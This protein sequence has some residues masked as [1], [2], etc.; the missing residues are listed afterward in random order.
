MLKDALAAAGGVISEAARLLG[1]SRAHAY[2]LY[3]RLKEEERNAAETQFSASLHGDASS[4]HGRPNPLGEE[5]PGVD[6]QP[7]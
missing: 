7:R 3:K 2:R 5:P 4:S 6:A 1:L